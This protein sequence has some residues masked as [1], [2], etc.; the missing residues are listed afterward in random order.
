[1]IKILTAFL[2]PFHFLSASTDAADGSH[3]GSSEAN[4]VTPKPQIPVRAIDDAEAGN[5]FDVIAIVVTI[6]EE[7]QDEVSGSA[8]QLLRQPANDQI[9]VLKTL[10]A[11]HLQ[12]KCVQKIAGV[13]VIAVHIIHAFRAP[14]LVNE[15][16]RLVRVVHGERS[17]L[18]A[19]NKVQ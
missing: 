14:D 7:L 11:A 6:L 13:L 12:S 2:G 9:V 17:V 10:C 1:M 5:N 19:T 15:R 16:S 4:F 8:V 3:I 18:W